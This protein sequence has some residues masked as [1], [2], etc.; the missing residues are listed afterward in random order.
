MNKYKS[1]SSVKYFPGW[2]NNPNNL[3]VL[4]IKKTWVTLTIKYNLSALNLKNSMIFFL[5]NVEADSEGCK[6]CL[7][8]YS[9]K[10]D[11]CYCSMIIFVDFSLGWIEYYTLY[12]EPMS[13]YL[14]ATNTLIIKSHWENNSSL[15]WMTTCHKWILA[16]CQLS[17]QCH[18]DFFFHYGNKSY[19][20]LKW[21]SIQLRMLL[22][23]I[24]SCFKLY[25]LQ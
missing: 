24:I 16:H 22:V 19:I 15:H 11:P 23:L 25:L 18:I 20:H 7:D 14:C 4:G 1:F 8:S 10:V 17:L 5:S 3:I 13:L 6:V 12:L 9:V 2:R 21:A